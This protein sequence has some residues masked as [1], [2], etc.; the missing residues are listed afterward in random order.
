MS[1]SIC[2][3]EII[4]KESFTLDDCEHNF[5]IKCIMKWFREGH[6]SCPNCRSEP[7]SAIKD[8]PAPNIIRDEYVRILSQTVLN[9]L[10]QN[11]H[12]NQHQELQTLLQTF[13]SIDNIDRNFTLKLGK[14]IFSLFS[15]K[16]KLKMLGTVFVSGACVVLITPILASKIILNEALKLIGF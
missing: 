13:T 15:L 8:I 10:Q 5:H 11:Q 4:I 2:L 12:E 7:E 14:I 16:L 9:Y 6:K 3:E 1:C